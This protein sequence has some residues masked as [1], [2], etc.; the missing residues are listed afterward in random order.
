MKTEVVD[1]KKYLSILLILM[2]S[3]TMFSCKKNA[4]TDD[5]YIESVG[6]EDNEKEQTS[7]S[8]EQEKDEVS[9]SK[10]EQEIDD[11]SKEEVQL[12]EQSKAET[13]GTVQSETQQ[14]PIDIDEPD[15]SASLKIEYSGDKFAEYIGKNSWDKDYSYATDE[16]KMTYDFSD[17]FGANHVLSDDYV[18]EYGI[19]SINSGE[20]SAFV[21]GV[22][23]SRYLKYSNQFPAKSK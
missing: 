1:M 23:Y 22:E 11:I 20:A 3:V 19:P 13:E 5:P 17:V 12:N 10:T 18:N 2:L 4:E 14:Q 9:E 6:R 8:K 21:D 15:D 16:Q 7:A